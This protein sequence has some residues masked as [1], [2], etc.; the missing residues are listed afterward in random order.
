MIVAETPRLVLR[1]FTPA[2]APAFMELTNEPAIRRYTGVEPYASVDEASQ[3]IDELLARYERDGFGRWVVERRADGEFLGWC[4]LRPVERE[5]IDLGFWILPR[6]WNQG[7][8]TEAARGSV[9]LAFGEL[10]LPYLLG[11]AVAKN[12]ASRAVLAKL[13]FEPWLKT[14]GHGYDDVRYT[15]LRRPDAPVADVSAGVVCSREGLDARL[16]QPA[17][18]LDFFMLEGNPNVLEYADGELISYE[19]AADAIT[20]LQDSTADLRVFAVSAPDRPFIGTLATVLEGHDRVE[21]GYR[22]LEEC[23]GRGY[24]HALGALALAL[25]RQEYPA[26]TIFGRCD[27]RNLASLSVALRLGG[28][29]LPDEDGHAVWEW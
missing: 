26:R 21:I 6:H 14:T 20:R 13:G 8:A 24:G 19:Q 2:D 17:D 4:G 18:Q 9:D 5:G 23:W 11:R 25:A 15:I 27:L 29:R 1:T 22:L 12:L 28:R 7:F 10:G 16:L 3:K